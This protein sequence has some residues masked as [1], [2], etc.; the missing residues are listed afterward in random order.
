MKVVESKDITI[1]QKIKDEFDNINRELIK[2][3]SKLGGFAKLASNPIH[4]NDKFAKQAGHTG[5]IAHGLFSFGFITKLLDDFLQ[6]EKYGKI[7][8][9][10]VE[11]RHPVR[12]GDKLITEAIV[13]KI[14]NKRIY[15]DVF[16]KTVTKIHLEKNGK[17]IKKYEA[18]ERNDIP[19]KDQMP[20]DVKS[21]EVDEGVLL[22]REKICSPGYAIIELFK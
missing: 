12:L 5:I 1:G 8:K 3:Y 21:K 11:M 17:I 13:K 14:K 15:F 9:V 16:Q 4:E 10:G 20:K 22:F 2:E 19:E 18:V 6:R 7:L